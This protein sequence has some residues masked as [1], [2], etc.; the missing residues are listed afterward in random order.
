MSMRPIFI[1]GRFQSQPLSG[2][3]RYAS[4]IV[5]ALDNLLAAR[6]GERPTCT[7]LVPRDARNTLDLAVI[8]Q[9]PVGRLRGHL[10]EQVDLPMHAA[11]GVLLSL[12]GTGPVAHQRHAVTIHDASV[13]ANPGNFSFAFRAWYR[14]LLPL[15]GR[16]AARVFTVSE[17]SKSELARYCGIPKEKIR[18]TYNGTEHLLRGRWDDSFPKRQG[19]ETGKYVLCVGADSPNKNVGLVVEALSR[20]DDAELVLVNVGANNS[21][22]FKRGAGGCSVRLR[23]LGHVPDSVLR[24]LYERALCVAFPSFYEGFGIPP[25]EAMV[26]GCPAVVARTSALPE[27]CGDAAMYCDPTDAGELAEHIRSL[28]QDPA[29]RARLRAS[30]IAHA[31]KFTWRSGARDI[32]NELLALS[33]QKR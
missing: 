14:T 31:R 7:L 18:V 8:E 33:V 23:S 32:L 2:V 27:V 16:S 4:E 19:L 24:A 12:A 29:L 22:V 1:N 3:Q 11:G 13:Y 28:R 17:F 5:F 6:G 25:L 20:I 26:C 10:W 15:L 30:G 21:R 9:K